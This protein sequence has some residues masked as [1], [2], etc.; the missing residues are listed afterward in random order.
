MKALNI[1]LT[2][3][4]TILG[5]YTLVSLAPFIINTT[6]NEMSRFT[7]EKRGCYSDEEF[8]LKILRWE[9]GYRY[10]MNNCLY[11]SLLEKIFDNCSCI[12]AFIAPLLKY[13]TVNKPPCR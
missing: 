4:N 8:Q 1:P 10:S 6:H 2:F 3:L 7:P 13:N 12:P 5:Q 9:D 11:S